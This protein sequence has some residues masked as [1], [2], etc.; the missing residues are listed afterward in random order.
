[1]SNAI[2]RHAGRALLPDA[3]SWA[4]TISIAETLVKSGVL[5]AHI[6]SP[7]AAVAIIQQGLELGIAPMT[8]LRGMFVIHG[9]VG[10]YSDLMLGLIYRDIGD[11]AIRVVETTSAQCT[12]AY[13]RPGWDRPATLTFTMDDAERAGLS[14]DNPAWK[15]YPAQMLRARAISAAARLGFPDLMSGMY[16]PEELGATVDADGTVIDV[17]EVSQ[18]SQTAAP[19]NARQIRDSAP[20]QANGNAPSN[21]HQIPEPVEVID[22]DTGEIIDAPMQVNDPS[23]GHPATEKQIKAIFGIGHSN[24]WTNA[25]IKAEMYERFL[26]ESTKDLTVAQASELIDVVSNPGAP[27]MQPAL[28]M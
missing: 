28:G 12:V 18:Q 8:A 25:E 26:I 24:G 2:T 27:D 16:T 9:K 19:S 22:G 15:K 13:Q 1:M 4:T 20:R 14:K 11:N 10:L 23:A 6:K 17:T 3:Q 5:P 7:Q 21:D